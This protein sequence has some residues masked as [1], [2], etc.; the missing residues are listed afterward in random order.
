MGEIYCQI[1]TNANNDDSY[2]KRPGGKEKM[3]GPGEYFREY[4]DNASINGFK[5]LAEKRPTIEWYVV[6]NIHFK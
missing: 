6:K 1:P 2:K 4:C 3:K 5:Y